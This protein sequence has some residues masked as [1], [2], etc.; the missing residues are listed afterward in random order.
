[1]QVEVVDDQQPAPLSE[2]M[3]STIFRVVRELLVNVSKHARTG[4]ARIAVQREGDTIRV[5]VEDEGVGFDVARLGMPSSSG[6]FGLYSIRQRIEYLGGSVSVAST[7]GS[8]T[9]T[10]ILAPINAGEGVKA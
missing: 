10:T 9:R 7:P 3:Q 2:E 8:G 5:T 1:M 6:G 4:K